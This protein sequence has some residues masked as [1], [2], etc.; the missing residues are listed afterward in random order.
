MDKEELKQFI[1]QILTKAGY[2]P[3]KKFA[4]EFADGIVFQTVFNIMFDEKIDCRL[5][6]S[7]LVEE[8]ILNWSRINQ[9]ICFNYLQQR[10][11]LVEPTMKSL[12]KG[13]NSDSIFKLLK[14]MIN[15]QQQ[16]YAEAT[17]DT[18]AIRDICDEIETDK[19]LF[20]ND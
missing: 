15:T 1:N 7:N 2:Q 9:M 20:G 12:A 3:V 14:V 6:P 18:S 17:K 13:T 11:Y 10:F 8:R 4:L 19:Q 5:R 16:I